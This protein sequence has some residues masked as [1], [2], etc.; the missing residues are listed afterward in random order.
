MFDIELAFLD[1]TGSRIQGTN[2]FIKPEIT[3]VILNTQVTLECYT[4]DG[5]YNGLNFGFTTPPEASANWEVSPVT[6]LTGGGIKISTSIVITRELNGTVAVCYAAG[7]KKFGNSRAATLIAQE[8]PNRLD[9]IR[10]CKLSRRVFFSWNNVPTL[11]GIDVRYGI[12]DNCKRNEMIDV[13]HYSIH[14]D[15]LGSGPYLANITVIL[16]APAANQVVN[17]KPYLLERH[18]TGNQI[19]SIIYIYFLFNAWSAI[20][21]H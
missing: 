10:V 5:E 14:L 18:I 4:Y 11:N 7:P 3:N 9:G 12:C 2:V 16:L 8:V 20:F 21:K 13:P 6:N 17:G 1:P 15:E 19:I